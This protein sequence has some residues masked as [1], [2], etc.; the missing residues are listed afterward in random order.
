[1]AVLGLESVI[2]VLEYW[3]IGVLGLRG[4]IMLNP[5]ITIAYKDGRFWASP[6]PEE[7]VMAHHVFHVQQC[8]QEAFL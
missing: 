6:M 1:M 4:V 8:N 7:P 2:G 5:L 3:S